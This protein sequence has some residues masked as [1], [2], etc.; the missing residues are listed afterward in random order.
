MNLRR[1]VRLGLLVTI[2][3]APVRGD[4]TYVDAVEGAAGNTF[5]TGG[6]QADTSWINPDTGSGS[7]DDQW[8]VRA[9]GNNATV[10]QALHSS[11]TMPELT[12]R[13]SGLSDGNYDIWVFFWDGPNSNTW[14][15]SAGLASG[16]L[17][18]YSFDGPGDTATPV[19]A[20]GLSFSNSPMVTEDVRTLYGVKLGQATVSG[21][22]DVDVFVDNL[23]GGG[24]NTRT[25]YDGVGYEPASTEPVD[26]DGDGLTDAEEGGLGTN[27]NDPD[28]D[29][30]GTPDGV[31]VAQGTDPT[32]AASVLGVPLVAIDFNRNDSLGSP[33]QSGFRVIGGSNTQAEN[34]NSYVKQVGALQVT[35]SRPE[36]TEFE[37]RGANGDGSRDIPGGD[38]SLS[39]LVSDLIATRDGAIDIEVTGLPA[40][41]YVFRSYHL[42]PFNSTAMGFAQ[43]S[44]NLLPNTVEGRVGG[45]LKGSV[46]TNALG[47]PGLNTT[48]IHDGN[49]PTL[50]FPFSYDGTGPMTVQVTATDSG[51]GGTFLMMNG[52]EILNA[53]AP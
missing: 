13:L 21:G 9:F 38:T 32:D 17:T 23:T 30:D 31:E 47:A 53:L 46:Q 52:F 39:Y 43:G 18:T 51:S 41:D 10:F 14:T 45:V 8:K 1:H 48:F 16:A 50:A 40:G 11:T 33:S 35:V 28:S 42:E 34:S 15:I 26:T 12:T 25:W 4:V 20:A 2:G 3:F 37:F 7:D 22:N 49:I 6:S 44:T 36:S 19:A 5:A 24:S 27:A 29:D